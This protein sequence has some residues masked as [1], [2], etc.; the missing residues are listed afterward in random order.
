MK[1]TISYCFYRV[2]R[3]KI[4]EITAFGAGLP[5]VFY[6]EKEERLD[7]GDWSRRGSG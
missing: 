4:M 7:G 2:S 3:L 6:I 5:R 1:N